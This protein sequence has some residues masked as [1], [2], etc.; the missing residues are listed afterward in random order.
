MST[1]ET[2]A[3]CRPLWRQFFGAQRLPGLCG[4]GFGPYGPG[5]VCPCHGGHHGARRLVPL[6]RQPGAHCR[7]DLARRSGLRAGPPLTQRQG[8]GAPVFRERKVERMALDGVFPVLHG[9]NGEDGSVQGL[10]QLA[11]FRWWVAAF[12]PLLCAWIRTGPTGWCRRRGSKCLHPSPWSRAFARRRPW[13]GA[14][15]WL[16]P[17]CEACPGRLILWGLQ[18]VSA[19]HCF[20]P[21]PLPCGMTNRVLVEAAMDGTE[22]GALSWE[23]RPSG[24][25]K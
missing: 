16:P 24:P 5:A 22:V 12:W 19:E 3:H 7:R 1:D 2:K 14:L 17:L 9:K 21:F 25:A 10:C 15:T 11:G 6:H 13:S 23:P 20:Q 4:R 8:P 18:G